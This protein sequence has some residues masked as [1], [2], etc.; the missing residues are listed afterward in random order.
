MVS[1]YELLGMIKDG[2]I[3]KRI[4]V[5]LPQLSYGVH[6]IAEYDYGDFS[7]YY[8]EEPK[9]GD[10][11]YKDYLGECFLE[12]DM[13]GRFI[14]VLDEEDEIEIPQ[15]FLADV[16]TESEIVLI[17]DDIEHDYDYRN[18]IGFITDKLCLEGIY[19]FAFDKRAN[20]WWECRF[21]RDEYIR[22]GLFV[23]DLIHKSFKA[24]PIEEEFE[25]IEEEKEIELYKIYQDYL[26]SN[27]T[28]TMSN[29]I[30]EIEAIFNETNDKINQLI[31]NQKKIIQKLNK[32]N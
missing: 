32:E 2:N 15:E 23:S 31:K 3:P 24:E 20:R 19:I 1:Y 9:E 18:S 17:K 13:F 8:I 27:F 25:D 26:E 4:Y 28:V 29:I 21:D 16:D 5:K 22:T 7:F 10:V 6:Y 11:N 12:S 30:S 14:R